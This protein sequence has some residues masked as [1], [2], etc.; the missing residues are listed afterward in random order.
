MI[1]KTCGNCFY[2]CK[3]LGRKEDEH[4]GICRRFPPSV[5]EDSNS[6]WWNP[7]V[8]DD[9]WCGEFKKKNLEVNK[10]DG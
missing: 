10:N 7:R 2:F 8:E 5:K 4:E 3:F 6:S 9:D 1:D